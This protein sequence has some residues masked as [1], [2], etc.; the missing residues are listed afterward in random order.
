MHDFC[1]SVINSALCKDLKLLHYPL[2]VMLTCVRC[3]VV[4]PLR[5]HRQ[6]CFNSSIQYISHACGQPFDLPQMMAGKH[7][8]GPACLRDQTVHHGLHFA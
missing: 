8:T 7:Q 6:V 5:L 4:Y 3:Y 1:E 2:E